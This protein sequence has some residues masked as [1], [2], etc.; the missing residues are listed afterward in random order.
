M[1]RVDLD[2]INRQL[3]AACRLGKSIARLHDGALV[4]IETIATD[5][6]GPYVE[7]N[8]FGRDSEV[9]RDCVVMGWRSRIRLR[10]ILEVRP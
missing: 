9:T 3:L 10:D 1:S 5:D 8:E 7:G 2:G 4:R 6:E